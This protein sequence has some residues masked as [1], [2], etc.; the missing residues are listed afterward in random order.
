MN[1]YV[2][3][4][5]ITFAFLM[6]NTIAFSLGF[7]FLFAIESL[8]SI[9]GLLAVGGVILA[10]CAAVQL[11]IAGKEQFEH[12]F[13]IGIV[14]IIGYLIAYLLL[15]YTLFLT[16]ATVIYSISIILQTL[17]FC[18]YF[19]ASSLLIPNLFI[20]WKYF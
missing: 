8:W 19:I 10:N 9:G 18:K 3:F 11:L 5:V 6:A 15:S 12:L 7:L 2:K 16:L 1:I 14:P 17:F 4:S 13:L 20:S